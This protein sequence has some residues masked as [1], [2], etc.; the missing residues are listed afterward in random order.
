MLCTL[1]LGATA[2][3][4]SIVSPCSPPASQRVDP[5]MCDRDDTNLIKN[6]RDLVQTRGQL[7]S[8]L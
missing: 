6:A 2:A 8:R 7:R 1:A 3:A 5:E 4:V